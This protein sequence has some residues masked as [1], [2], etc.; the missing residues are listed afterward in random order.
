MKKTTPAENSK[1]LDSDLREEYR[2]DY[3]QACPNRFASSLGPEAV[4]VVLEP[5]VASVCRDPGAV[6]RLLRSAIEEVPKA[7]RSAASRRRRSAE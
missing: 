6:S 7:S 3:R 1:R 5:D 4:A 2:F